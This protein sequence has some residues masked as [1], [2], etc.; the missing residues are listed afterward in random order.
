MVGEGTRAVCCFKRRAVVVVII[1]VD[2]VASLCSHRVTASPSDAAIPCSLDSF[3]FPS[4]TLPLFL[5]L[6]TP[7]AAKAAAAARGSQAGTR[8]SRFQ[9]T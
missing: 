1:S 6:S 7:D 3:P 4:F 8:N 2:V 5:A 9:G